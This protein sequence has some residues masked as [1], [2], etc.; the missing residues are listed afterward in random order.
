MLISTVG[1]TIMAFMQLLTLNSLYLMLVAIFFQNL[2]NGLSYIVNIMASDVLD[3]QQWKTG[4]RSE[5]V[6]FAFQT[7]LSK[8]TAGIAGVVTG[9]VLEIGKYQKPI[10]GNLDING[11]QILAQQT[12]FTQKWLLI[13]VTLLPALGFLLTMIPMFFIDYTVKFKEKIQY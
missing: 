9:W 11:K 4:K 1:F 7:F 10:D 3:Y 5:G 12:P 6:C 13:M 2:F 8:V